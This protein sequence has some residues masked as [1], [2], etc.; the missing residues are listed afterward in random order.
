MVLVPGGEFLYGP[1][2]RRV[3]KRPFYIDRFPVTNE[4]LGKFVKATGHRPGRSICGC[5]YLGAGGDATK[6]WTPDAQNP[7]GPAVNV[8]WIDAIAYCAWAGKELPT[9]TRWEKAARGT[10]GRRYPW[11]NEPKDA[12]FERKG[13]PQTVGEGPKTASPYGVEEMLGNVWELTVGWHT[14]GYRLKPE[15]QHLIEPHVTGGVP[16]KDMACVP[17]LRGGRAFAHMGQRT[18]LPREVWRRLPYAGLIGGPCSEG[19][20]QAHGTGPDSVGF[21][22]VLVPQPAKK[23]GA[24]PSGAGAKAAVPALI[25][26]LGH[27]DRQVRDHAAK[28]LGEIG[29]PA[30]PALVE[31]LKE[32]DWQVR[33]YA[34]KVLGKLGSDARA[35]VPA[36]IEALK[37]EHEDVRKAAAEALG[38]TGSDGKAAVPALMEALRDEHVPVRYRAADALGSIGPDAKAAVPALIEALKDEHEDVRE[39]AVEAL[40]KVGPDARAAVPALSQALKDENEHVRRGAA[41]ALKR[42]QAEE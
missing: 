4:R 40:G 32:E 27:E 39:A 9:E 20:I 17:V 35:A 12:V 33:H 37:D 25:K 10:D 2:R 19:C 14:K 24:E 13:G 21:R 3:T 34:A 31:T 38:K 11:G 41:E 7:D 30:I 36:L 16:I 8:T 15:E 28:A 5:C 6:C 29:S 23:P 1:D 18:E 42:I 26:A 22:C